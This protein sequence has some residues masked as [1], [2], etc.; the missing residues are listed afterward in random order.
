[1]GADLSYG[2]EVNRRAFLTRLSSGI[3]GLS[4]VDVQ[5][6]P[7]AIRSAIDPTAPLTDI[8]AIT[9]A[10][11]RELVEPIDGNPLSALRGRFV[12]GDYML[13]GANGFDQQWNIGV[14]TGEDGAV[15]LERYLSPA[16]L[17]MRHTLVQRRLTRFGALP[18]PTGIEG[19]VATDHV[20]GVTVRGVRAYDV[21]GAGFEDEET[22]EWVETRSPGWMLRFDVLG[23][24]A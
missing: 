13:G 17:Q 3:I 12:P 24:A 7:T 16:A 5:W 20:S 9:A 21:I 22:G 2:A 18:L 23:S 4:L 19:A 6:V 1:M 15:D 14:D 10:F 11:L 8:N